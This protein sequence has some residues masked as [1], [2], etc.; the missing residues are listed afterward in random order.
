MWVRS[1]LKFNVAIVR[2]GLLTA[3]SNHKG[4]IND[5][6]FCGSRDWQGQRNHV[7]SGGASGASSVSGV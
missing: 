1:V 7:V 6:Q 3:V 4:P 5:F 2:E